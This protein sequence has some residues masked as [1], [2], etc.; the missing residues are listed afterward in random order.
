M[1]S[2][3]SDITS[4][5][6]FFLFLQVKNAEQINED[7]LSLF[8][9]LVPKLGKVLICTT[10]FTIYFFPSIITFTTIRKKQKQYTVDRKDDIL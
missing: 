7:S 5:L 1:H 10:P 9:L 3:A 6:D 4:N 8:P 2:R